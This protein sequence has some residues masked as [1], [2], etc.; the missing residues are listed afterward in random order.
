MIKGSLLRAKIQHFIGADTFE[1]YEMNSRYFE[2]LL[3]RL[4]AKPEDCFYIDKQT[5]VLGVAA[6]LGIKTFNVEAY[7]RP[8]FW[9]QE[10]IDFI[11]KEIK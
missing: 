2:M 6:K 4:K 3:N 11:A 1:Q 9:W 8:Q 7:H 5:Q 10:L